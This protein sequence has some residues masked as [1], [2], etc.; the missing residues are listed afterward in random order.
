[1]PRPA[2]SSLPPQPRQ[3]IPSRRDIRHKPEEPARRDP[4]EWMPV[5]ERL[6]VQPFMFRQNDNWKPANT[7]EKR[8]DTADT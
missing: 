7:G 2:P 4:M 1:L 5:S 3:A 6:I 8:L